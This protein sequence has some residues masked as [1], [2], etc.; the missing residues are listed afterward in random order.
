MIFSTKKK[1]RKRIVHDNSI[2]YHRKHRKILGFPTNRDRFS[3]GEGTQK[4]SFQD[5]RRGER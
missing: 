4:R 1:S 2:V 3:G 5:Q